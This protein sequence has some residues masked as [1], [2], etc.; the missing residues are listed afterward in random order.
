MEE[1][2]PEGWVYAKLR[3]IVYPGATRN[4]NTLTEP[5]FLYVDIEAL[6]NSSQKIVNPK[7]LP[8]SE[9]PG[10][11]RMVIHA[12]DVIFS[13]TRPYLKN[14]AIVP[15][16]L[17]DQI[18]STAYC[19]MRP[20]NG[21]SSQFIFYLVTR[22][23]FINSIVTYG[24][25]PPAAHDD[26]FLAMKIPLAP[27]KEQHRIVAAIEQQ[28]SRLDNAIA[29]L[30]NAKAKAKQYRASLLKAA[31]EGE[32]TKAWRA[33]H[34]ASETGAQLLRRI[35]AER[36]ARWEEEQL[37]KKREKG[38]VPKDDRWKQAYK[39]PQGPNVEELPELPEEWCWATVEQLA[40][41]DKHA[42]AI[43]PFG[44]DLKVEDYRSE[45]VPLIFVRNIRSETFNG[46]NAKYITFDKAEELKAH[47]VISGDI[48]ITKMGDPPGDACLYPENMP[49]AIIT[50]DCI[51]WTLFPLLSERK[52]FVKAINSS[53][54][55]D[56]IL[57]I[58]K[59][60]A[61]QKVSLQRFS[62]IAI[63]LPPLAEQAQIVA[64][65]EASLSNI[66]KLEEA[67][68]N[69]LKRAEHERQSILRE[70]FAGKLVPQDPNDEPA[71]ALLERIREERK[72]REEAEKVLKASQKGSFMEMAKRRKNG[73]RHQA[74]ED[75]TSRQQVGLYEKLVE[76][77]GPLPPDGLFK[78]AG[79]KADEQP[80]SV[81]QFYG[82]L[83][84]DV[85]DDLIEELRP[86]DEHVLL[87]ALEPS[88]ELLAHM[89]GE[90]VKKVREK[91]EQE[92]KRIVER[93]TLWDDL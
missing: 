7:K 1:K 54:V 85:I 66:A 8:S 80:E 60:V 29:S 5:Y 75:G 36:R 90:A 13:L 67:A 26:E 31:V 71:S 30:Q 17:D 6:D 92:E 61:Q 56:Q 18:A 2:L 53:I 19:V 74:G 34:P 47:K 43:G 69:N 25:S 33:E 63:P 72:R 58:T 50:A 84:A 82:E 32:L 93:R 35:L 86:D 48:L 39:E 83:H 65:I 51:K 11:A 78:Q 52:F 15:P 42:L 46:H 27:T 59:G 14:I 9:A 41:V 45:G 24:D 44:S 3:D 28:F 64:E 81:E 23:D 4:P 16:E 55:R 76:A 10:R 89:E 70:A 57:R 68:E 37:A 40:S 91:G 77:G 62:G 22:D 38:I 12:N 73:K 20:E 21:I 87:K 88:E 79:L 49:P